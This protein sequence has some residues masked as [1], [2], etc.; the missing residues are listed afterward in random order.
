MSPVHRNTLLIVALPSAL[1]VASALGQFRPDV[2]EMEYSAERLRQAQELHLDRRWL[3][4]GHAL[5]RNAAHARMAREGFPGPSAQP[6]WQSAHPNLYGRTN[7]LHDAYANLGFAALPHSWSSSDLDLR[8]WPDVAPANEPLGTL[9]SD[10]LS[11][12]IVQAQ[13]VACHVEGGVSGHTRLVFSRS[14]VEGHEELNRKVFEDFV[15]TVDGG[16]DLILEKVQGIAH[17]GGIQL[18]AGTADFANLEQF[19]RGLANEETTV[20]ELTA[21]TLF[22]G[23]TMMT[24]AK[25]LRRAAIL[26]AG[27]LPTQAELDSVADGED[28]S[29]RA[30]VRGLMAGVEFHDFL[31]RAGND[32]LLTDRH[33]ERDTVAFDSKEFVEL[34]RKYAEVVRA[35]RGRGFEDR[36]RDPDFWTWFEAVRAGFARAPLELIA[37]VVENDLP[38]TEI[39]T[40]DYIMAN[41]L[42]AEA[43][44]DSV[45]EFDN[46]L[47]PFEY[48]PSRISSYYRND[49]SKVTVNEDGIGRVV[50]S[51]GNLSTNYPHA[52]VLNTTVFLHR[53]PST[54]TNRNRARSRWT[55][56]HF[57]GVDVE[58]SAARTTDP[59]ALT[60]TNNPTLN[61]SACTVCHGVLDPVAGTFQNYGDEGLYRHEWGGLDSLPHLYKRPEDGSSSPYVH[62]DTWYRDM[63]APGF[64]GEVAPD[65]SNSVQWLARRIVE[66]DRFAEA[67]VKFWWPAIMGVETLDPPEDSGDSGARAHLVAATAQ[68]AE[69]GRLGGLF[70]TGI[71]GG[72]PY[73]GRHLLAEITL[74]PWFRAESVAG[75]DAERAA[76]LASA[77]VARMLT[78]AELSRKTEAVT[79]YVWDRVIRRTTNP[80]G[81]ET[82]SLLRNPLPWDNEYLL[83]YGGIDSDGLT[84]RAGDITPVMAAVAQSH[85]AEISCPIISREFFLLDDADRLLFKGISRMDTPVS[86]THGSFDVGADSWESREG[87]SLMAD[88]AGGPKTIRI[89][90]ANDFFDD[91]TGNDR[92][93][94]VDSVIVRDSAGSVVARV[95]VENLGSSRC[96]S[97]KGVIDSYQTIVCEVELPLTVS[98]PRDDTYEIEIVAFQD[99]AGDEAA[100]MTVVVESDDGASAGSRAIRGKLVE[101]HSKLLGV[102]VA[103]DSIDVEEAYQLFRE[104]WERKRRYEGGRFSDSYFRCWPNDIRYFDGLLEGSP[105]YNEHHIASWSS[106]QIDE[107]YERTDMTDPSHAVRAWVATLAF[108]MSDFRYLYL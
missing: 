47:D 77:G 52:G 24:P 80:D 11:E 74:S 20:A 18:A 33:L 89:A 44:G 29:L 78:P 14:S 75:D 85:V 73:I 57:L 54:A 88:L 6:Q 8:P 107:L 100:R 103:P 67:T 36:W 35:S 72:D 104:V 86:E 38:Y 92:N 98:V 84:T 26:F 15:E 62:G 76:A 71:A 59:G 69:V 12:E 2:W 95:E 68:Q 42:V 50:T 34:N 45:T 16:A 30:A 25:T 9:F 105:Q 58:K 61:N 46:A 108:L 37:H 90:F 82:H 21:E 13:C 40:A 87:Y 106:E 70:R 83:L 17:G 51:P 97:P 41:P 31:I 19:L 79:G 53:Y 39:M 49:E 66:D 65:A 94:N 91:A 60:D 23:V 64:G 102:D 96:R 27:R 81:G 101:L 10:Y 32:R 7:V 48:R 63:R 56:Y 4:V 43:Y 22:E 3:E 28:A 55:Y 5:R 1:A 99:A 93:L